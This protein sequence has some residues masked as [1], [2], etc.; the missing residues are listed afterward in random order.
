M[1]LFAMATS[2]MITSF[3]QAPSVGTTGFN[4]AGYDQVPFALG[5]AYPSTLAAT[6]VAGTGF[7]F[8]IGAIGA[9]EVTQSN[10]GTG[11]TYN[12][13]ISA[14]NVTPGGSSLYQTFAFTSTN[15]SRFKLNTVKVRVNNTSF[16]PIPMVLAGVINGANAG[17]TINFVALPGSRFYTVNTSANPNFYN[18]NGVIAINLTG[19]TAVAEMAF[20]DINIAAAIPVPDP[21]VFTTQPTNK[22]VCAGSTT[23]FTGTAPGA[24][25]Y[26]WL[27]SADGLIW[28]KVTAATAGGT[29]V[30]YT[31]NTLSVKPSST[32]LNGYQFGVVALNSAGGYKGSNAAV[33]TVIAAPAT[34]AVSGATKLCTGLTTTLTGA[35]A[36]GVWNSLN[37][38]VTINASTGVV[39]GASVGIASIKYTVTNDACSNSSIYNSLAV[40]TGGAIPSI[41]YAL[42]TVN[43]QYGLGGTFCANKTFTVVGSPAGGTW[44]S[45]G[46]IS[47]GSSTGV[48][49]TGTSAGA[50]SI[51][52]S[53]ANAAGCLSS[54]T[55]TGSVSICASKGLNAVSNAQQSINTEFT[56]YPNPAKSAISLS[57][58]S[59]IG[60]GKI[61][62]TDL[63]G[64]QV[65]YHTLSLGNNTIDIAN[66]NKGVYLVSVSTRAGKSTKK[67]IVE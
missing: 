54:R 67:L 39:T 55:I 59:V 6:N 47:I 14:T 20:D 66:L 16:L 18:I 64:K 11:G 38:R 46:F 53:Y 10:Y 19:T 37:N 30:G 26:Y 43:P 40:S 28:N 29:F 23:T 56:M 3:S 50:A 49:N 58:A 8:Y 27:I 17:D 13:A 48:V 65:K 12:G 2:F 35:P 63:M 45:S 9:Y 51:T 32:G 34:P 22:S 44:T 36:G 42:G 41:G 4:N 57:V 33:L 62:V 60:E 5:S 52:Y 24:V 25:S 15:N 31:T 7:N 61:M 21:P 1:V